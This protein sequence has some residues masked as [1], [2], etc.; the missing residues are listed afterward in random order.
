[1]AGIMFP[2]SFFAGGSVVPLPATFFHC[3]NPGGQGRAGPAMDGH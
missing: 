1:M 2:D 3:D